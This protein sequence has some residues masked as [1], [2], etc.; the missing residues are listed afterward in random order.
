MG[1][2]DERRSDDTRIALILQTQETMAGQVELMLKI[3]NGNGSAGLKTKVELNRASIVRAWVW[4]SSVS[5]GI[6]GLA[7]WAIRSKM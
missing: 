1:P 4:L 6:M 7:F 2:E 3:L 5:V